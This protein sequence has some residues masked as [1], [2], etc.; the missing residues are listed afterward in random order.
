MARDRQV[1]Q[2][3]RPTPERYFERAAKRPG[4]VVPRPGNPLRRLRAER[5]VDEP[6]ERVVVHAPYPGFPGGWARDQAGARALRTSPIAPRGQSFLHPPLHRLPD[7]GMK[8]MIGRAHRQGLADQSGQVPGEGPRANRRRQTGQRVLAFQVQLEPGTVTLTMKKA[9]HQ[10]ELIGPGRVLVRLA[11]KAPATLPIGEPLG[12][13]H[14]R[15]TAE[16]VR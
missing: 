10:V 9:K 16:A 11:L 3:I 15:R 12:Q 5:V 8:G 6:G 13:D 2:G 4:S 14:Q 1:S 7:L